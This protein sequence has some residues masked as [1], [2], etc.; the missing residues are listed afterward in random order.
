MLLSTKQAIFAHNIA[1]LIIWVNSIG[2]RV[3][4]GEAYRTIEQAELNARAGKG[5]SNSLHID[6]LAVDL[7]LY[8]AGVYQTGSESYRHMGAYWKSLDPLNRWGG[9]FVDEKGRAKP[10]GNHFSMEHAGRK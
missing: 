10:D 5:I 8:V 4:F 2:D 7:N 9:D 1:K 6:R 3:T